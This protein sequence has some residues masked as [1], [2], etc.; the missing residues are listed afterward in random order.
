MKLYVVMHQLHRKISANAGISFYW[1]FCCSSFSGHWSK[2]GWNIGGHLPFPFHP[3]LFR[4]FLSFPSISFLFRQSPAIKWILVHSQLT[5]CIS[6]QVRTMTFV[7]SLRKFIV[8]E[9]KSV[10]KLNE[11]VSCLIL[12]QIRL[13]LL[14][15]NTCSSVG[16]ISQLGSTV[17]FPSHEWLTQRRILRVF[18]NSPLKINFSY[19]N[20]S[21]SECCQ[22]GTL[23]ALLFFSDII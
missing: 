4:L 9:H 11:R 5:Y 8:Q 10:T 14:T 2:I 17:C 12:Y 1:P 3:L 20:K 19:E 13:K 15:G 23:S 21:Y 6:G 22:Y 7:V 18:N 16:R